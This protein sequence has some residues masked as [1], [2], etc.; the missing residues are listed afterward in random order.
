MTLKDSILLF[1]KKKWKHSY[2]R[3]YILNAKWNY[4]FWLFSKKIYKSKSYDVE[5]GEYDV[6]FDYKL[7]KRK[8]KVSKKRFVGYL[9]ENNIYLDNPGMKIEDRETWEA[10]KRK[11]LID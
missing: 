7:M 3:F 5:V 1:L 10:W 9:F 6:N 11:K 2:V 4:K 8:E